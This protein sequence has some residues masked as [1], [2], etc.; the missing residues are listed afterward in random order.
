MYTVTAAAP[1]LRHP[2]QNLHVHLNILLHNLPRQ[3]LPHPILVTNHL[4]TNLL[5]NL[6]LVKAKAAVLIPNQVAD[7]HLPV[8][9]P[10]LPVIAPEATPVQAHGEVVVEPAAAAVVDGVVAAGVDLV[11][12]A[13][14]AAVV[15]VAEEEDKYR[16]VV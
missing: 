16:T 9:C 12:A 8:K 14:E 6:Q 1:G 4:Q 10:V 3:N 2:T 15:S 13:A 11:A 7:L 5:L